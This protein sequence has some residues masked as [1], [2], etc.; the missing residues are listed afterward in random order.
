MKLISKHRRRILFC[1]IWVFFVL[2]GAVCNSIKNVL[3][4]TLGRKID[5]YTVA[6]ASNTFML[7][8]L[9]VN[10]FLHNTAT[11]RPEFWQQIA[12]ML[13][14]EILAM[15]LFFSALTSSRLSHSFPFVSFMPVFVAIGSFFI[16]GERVGILVYLG[17]ILIVT[18]AFLLSMKKGNV[19]A[20]IRGSVYIL[21]VAGLWG[22]LIP[23]GARAVEYSSAQLYPA[24][25]FTLATLLFLPIFF[26]KKSSSSRAVFRAM[27]LFLLIGMFFGLFQIANW[28]AYSIGPAT[29]ISALAMTSIPITA[30]F[31]S[32]REKEFPSL[33]M[34]FT[35]VLM[36]VGAMVVIVG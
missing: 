32:M 12:L 16:L 3:T 19:K 33:F 8:V 31:D 9:W 2:F 35:I 10:V 1:M 21:A 20:D 34:I 26:S 27:P 15:F 23:M 18:G 5:V 17:A 14:F 11:I 28:Y 7:P 24:I 13:P 30:L 22:Y 4:R 29:A 36:T 6:I 25:Y